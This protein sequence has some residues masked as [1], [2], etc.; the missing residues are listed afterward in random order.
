M[1]HLYI[2]TVI[3]TYN[4]AGMLP[5]ALASALAASSPGDEVVVIDDGS[6]DNTADAVAP[7][8]DRIRYVR[9]D[10]RGTG[11]ARNRG[12]AEA[13][14]DLVAFLDSDDEW[15]PDKLDLQRA[16]MEARPDVLFCFTEFAKRDDRT[17]VTRH[18][19]SR[20]SNRDPRPWEKII[21]APLAADAVGAPGES[22]HDFSIN[23][24][25]LY[26][27]MMSD[28]WLFPGTLLARKKAAGEAFRCSEDIAVCD[29]WVMA[30]RLARIG[31]GAFVDRETAV[32]HAHDG[33][34][35][36][37][38]DALTMATSRVRVLERVWGADDRF[39]A[40]NGDRYRALMRERRL[41]RIFF[42]LLQ[43]QAREARGELGRIGDPPR[44]Y[45]LLSSLPGPLARSLL[46][47]YRT[48]KGRGVSV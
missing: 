28:W 24:G 21:G 8:L 39:L 13:R 46:G 43:G 7:F 35:L 32:A 42:L 27:A 15:L 31:H 2:S 30:G 19:L 16:V 18:N 36:L 41:A 26:P 12:I 3:P 37:D 5:R 23:I 25:D 9:T 29:D 4:R 1:S 6:T 22:G 40:E 48:Y 44:A 14:H 33:G 10:N 17:G 38:A 11:A 47:A 20:S 45:R 34:Q